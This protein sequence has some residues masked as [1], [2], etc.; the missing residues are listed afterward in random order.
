MTT[1][2]ARSLCLQ[3]LLY[4]FTIW[5]VEVRCI[6]RYRQVRGIDSATLVKVVPH[7]FTGTKEVVLLE[8]A[9]LVSLV[10]LLLNVHF[11][12]LL[13]IFVLL[14]QVSFDVF[15]CRMGIPMSHFR[16]ESSV[17]F[18]IPKKTCFER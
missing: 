15:V 3:I 8:R 13:L 1:N 7:T 12:L 14:C 2:I 16:L 4:L 6:V 18:G 9:V 11:M 10:Q 17:S 5:S